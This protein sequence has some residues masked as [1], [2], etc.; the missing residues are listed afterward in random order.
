[1]SDDIVASWPPLSPD[2]EADV[3]EAF[4]RPH[5]QLVLLV[6]AFSDGGYG[7]ALLR[8][9]HHTIG[10]RS[11]LAPREIAARCG[12]TVA[13]GAIALNHALTLSILHLQ[14]VALVTGI[15]FAVTPFLHISAF[16]VP[17]TH[18]GEEN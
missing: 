14:T 8:P 3:R 11:E 15:K 17:P 10:A 4:K 16:D 1:M 7:A 18:P 12:L 13:Q 6:F 5:V 9:D 2:T